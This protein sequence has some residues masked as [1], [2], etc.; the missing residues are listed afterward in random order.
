MTLLDALPLMSR[1]SR[2]RY[3]D[4]LYRKCQRR[5]PRMDR[6]TAR[7]LYAYP[8]PEYP[9]RPYLTRELRS[10]SIA[11]PSPHEPSPRIQ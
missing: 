10:V 2:D 5:S 6:N 3:F 11:N 8:C 1:R 4:A 7:I 9:N